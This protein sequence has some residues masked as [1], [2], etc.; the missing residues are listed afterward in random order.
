[1]ASRQ[2]LSGAQKRKLKFKKDEQLKKLKGSLDHF[3]KPQLPDSE[4]SHENLNT[5]SVK[6]MF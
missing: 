1:M 2:Y 3:I 5:K 4:T 6:G